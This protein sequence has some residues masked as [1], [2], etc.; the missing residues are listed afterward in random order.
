MSYDEPKK[1]L[2]VINRMTLHIEDNNGQVQIMDDGTTIADILHALS[3]VKSHREKYREK[4]R[5]RYIP[6]KLPKEPVPET[7]KRP[8]G[9]PRKNPPA[10]KIDENLSE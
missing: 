3:L 9:R 1:I 5:K 8:R 2:R 10:S 6:K 4:Y 7:P